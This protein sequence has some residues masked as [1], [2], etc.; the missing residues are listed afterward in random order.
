MLR[1][2]PFQMIIL[3]M[4]VLSFP[5]IGQTKT[6]KRDDDKRPDYINLQLGAE[7]SKNEMEPVGFLHD[8]QGLQSLEPY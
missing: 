6:E 3:A 1:V 7:L 2:R 4:L 5:F 8:L